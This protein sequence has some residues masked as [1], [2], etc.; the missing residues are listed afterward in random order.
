MVYLIFCFFECLYDVFVFYF[1][2]RS[3]LCQCFDAA[4]G[5]R[6]ICAAHGFQIKT[7]LLFFPIQ[8][9]FNIILGGFAH[10]FPIALRDVP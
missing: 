10:A 2:G 4:F 1:M 3:V 7:M 5:Y 9:R 6:L 8:H